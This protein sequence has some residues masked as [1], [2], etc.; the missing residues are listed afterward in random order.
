MNKSLLTSNFSSEIT[1]SFILTALPLTSLLISLFELSNLDSKTRSTI[2]IF[3]F[4]FLDW[5]IIFGKFAPIEFPEKA[6]FAA[7]SE[8]LA[9]CFPWSISV[10]LLASN[11]FNS[12]ISLDLNFSISLI[13]ISVKIFKNFITSLSST[14]L[15]NCQ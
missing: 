4:I 1:L 2:L 6:S 7:Y 15:Q 12:L 14:F 8:F 5:I 11:I 9:A 10:V 3:S 13:S